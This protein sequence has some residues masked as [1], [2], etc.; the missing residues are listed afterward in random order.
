[1]AYKLIRREPNGYMNGKK[2]FTCDTANDISSLPTNT[3]L[4]GKSRKTIPYQMLYA[5]LEA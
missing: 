3:E 4:G 2:Y 1:M 5:V